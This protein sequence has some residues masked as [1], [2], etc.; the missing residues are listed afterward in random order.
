MEPKKNPPTTGHRQP[1]IAVCGAG[2]CDHQLAAVAEE[3]GRRVAQAG[4]LLGCVDILPKPYQHP[5]EMQKREIA[6]GQFLEPGKDATIV[7]D[8]IDRD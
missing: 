3:V 4:A 6:T 2:A 7:L 8:F 5:N 1:I